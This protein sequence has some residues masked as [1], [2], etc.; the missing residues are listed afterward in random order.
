MAAYV[1][2]QMRVQDLETYRRYAMQV[3]ETIKPF[4]GRLLVANDRA[5]VLEGSQPWPRTVIGEFASADE[6]RR[7]YESDAYQAIQPLRASSSEGTVYIVEGFSLPEA[8]QR[9]EGGAA[10]QG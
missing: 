7:W 10:T 2:A 5:D 3:A 9:V 6:A 4:S 1:I 8:V